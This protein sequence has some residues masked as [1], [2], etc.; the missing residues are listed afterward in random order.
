MQIVLTSFVKAGSSGLQNLQ[1]A[2]LKLVKVLVLS[3]SGKKDFQKY[4]GI[5]IL[6]SALEKI[7]A[8]KFFRCV[9]DVKLIN[10]LLCPLDPDYQL[11]SSPNSLSALATSVLRCSLPEM[12]LPF[13]EARKRR[14]FDVPSSSSAN[15]VKADNQLVEPVMA[16]GQGDTTL[17]SLSEQTNHI[18]KKLSTLFAEIHGEGAV[19]N[20]KTAPV[21]HIQPFESNGVPSYNCTATPEKMYKRPITL[22]KQII[23]AEILKKSTSTLVY[24]IMNSSTA[25]ALINNPDILEFDSRFESG[26]LQIAMQVKEFEYDLMVQSDINTTCGK[27]NQWFYFSV[28]KMIPNK[29]Y[30]FNIINMSKA[31]SQFNQGMQ[32]VMFSAA[33]N[34]WSRGGENIYYYKNHYR[35]NPGEQVAYTYASLTFSV[36]FEH[37]GDTC[38]FA[39]RTFFLFTIKDASKCPN[40]IRP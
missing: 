5:S 14:V 33:K 32:P 24:N 17:S 3:E 21:F 18:D 38:W 30:K 35:Q 29:Q 16:E 23:F 15:K 12:E 11:T 40:F 13:K 19:L 4:G 2:I 28:K 20:N 26:N 39:Y 22:A 37:E 7:L 9:C 27:H 25:A 31:N 8:R 6:H 36:T 1:K 10:N 34:S